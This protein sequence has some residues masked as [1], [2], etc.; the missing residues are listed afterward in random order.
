[1]VKILFLL[2]VVAGA[3]ILPFVFIRRPWALR[4]WSRFKI[5]I[6]VY[7]LV[8]LAVGIARLVFNWDEIYG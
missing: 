1:V 3:A 6:L 2:L 8:I 7:A 5:V 4:L